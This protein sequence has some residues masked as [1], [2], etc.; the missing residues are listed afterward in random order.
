LARASPFFDYTKKMDSFYSLVENASTNDLWLMHGVIVDKLKG[1]VVPTT[2]SVS[3]NL[4]DTASTTSSNR[5]KTRKL[6][7]F[8]PLFK[9][10]DLVSPVPCYMKALDNTV[11]A[12]LVFEKDKVFFKTDGGLVFKNPSAFAK[13]HADQITPLHP[14]PTKSGDGWHHIKF[15]KDD[16]RLGSAFKTANTVVE[17]TEKKGVSQEQKTLASERSKK[18]AEEAHTILATMRATNPMATYNDAQK[19]LKKRK[20][21]SVTKVGDVNDSSDEDDSEP[22]YIESVVLKYI[23]RLSDEELKVADKLL[24]QKFGMTETDAEHYM[25]RVCN[26]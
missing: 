23:S 7:D 8:A 5:M 1:C 25:T 3:S 11:N 2:P 26:Q 19:E 20:T 14:K 16:K 17:K 12:N 13:F 15:A 18:W 9:A 10:G 22:K 4:S 21:E 6:S 24:M